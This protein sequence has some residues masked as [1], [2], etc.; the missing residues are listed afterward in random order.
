MKDQHSAVLVKA[1]NMQEALLLFSSH[2][3]FDLI[4]YKQNL[5]DE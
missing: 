2:P 1:G 4:V 3:C 5:S